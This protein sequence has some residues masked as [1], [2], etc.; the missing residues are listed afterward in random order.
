MRVMM[1]HEG[2][3]ENIKTGIWPECAATT[4]KLENIKV[5][6]HKEKCAHEKFYGKIPDYAK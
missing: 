3:H 5:N 4:T 1:V 6:P 2:L